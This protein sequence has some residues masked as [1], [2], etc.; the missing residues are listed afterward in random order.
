MGVDATRLT[1]LKFMGK[2]N[3][4]LR[5]VR[6]KGQFSKY[7]R[8]SFQ[9]CAT[10]D[11]LPAALRKSFYNFTCTARYSQYAI[12][13]RSSYTRV[14]EL[15]H[16]RRYIAVSS[17]VILAFRTCHRLYAISIKLARLRHLA[18]FRNEITRGI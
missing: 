8:P 6:D 9:R 5:A 17:H 11:C 14:R 7:T 1:R 15:C 2:T 12:I 13:T 10:A 18:D 3:S 4:W 16:A